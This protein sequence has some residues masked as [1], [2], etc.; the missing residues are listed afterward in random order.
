MFGVA[1]F[2]GGNR[3]SG[4]CAA[5]GRAFL[6]TTRLG[7]SRPWRPCLRA[8]ALCP[9]S[10]RIL[11]TGHGARSAGGPHGSRHGLPALDACADLV[12]GP[13]PCRGS[14]LASQPARPALWCRRKSGARSRFVGSGSRPQWQSL[15]AQLPALAESAH[16]AA[17]CQPALGDRHGS[18]GGHDG[19]GARERTLAT[20]PSVASGGPAESAPLAARSLRWALPRCAECPALATVAL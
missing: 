4:G 19:S 15:V 13:A 11:D 8:S 5:R 18:A 16:L 12:V 6:G 20:A 9:R 3:A 1:S 2:A 14:D 17:G 7:N 10:P